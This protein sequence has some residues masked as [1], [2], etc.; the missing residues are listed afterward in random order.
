MFMI[1][2]YFLAA[3]NKKAL[4][5]EQGKMMVDVCK[6]CG[7]TYVIYS[8]AGDL[9]HFSEKVLHIKG[10]IDV[11]NYLKASGLRFGILRPVAFFGE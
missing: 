2:D 5:I 3:K 1:T 4:E 8:S 6:A 11:E 7:V 9:E 10:K